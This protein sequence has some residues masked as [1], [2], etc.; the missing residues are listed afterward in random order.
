MATRELERW[1]RECERWRHKLGLYDW[2]LTYTINDDLDV[3]QTGTYKT[4]A[5][6]TYTPAYKMAEVEATKQCVTG[7]SIKEAACHEMAHLRLAEVDIFV[8]S[9]LRNIPKSARDMADDNWEE[10]KER[11]VT[12]W[13]KALM[14]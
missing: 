12:E 1:K 4:G 6:T 8:G 13:Q 9:L 3:N 10:I 11:T 7:G 5:K 14:R 2:T